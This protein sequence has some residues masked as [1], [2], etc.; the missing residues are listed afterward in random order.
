[1]N[2]CWAHHFQVK[3]PEGEAFE[4]DLPEKFYIFDIGSLSKQ[5]SSKFEWEQKG[6]LPSEHLQLPPRHPHLNSR[7]A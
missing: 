6:T 1:M 4:V 3:V 7:I 5:S 2:T